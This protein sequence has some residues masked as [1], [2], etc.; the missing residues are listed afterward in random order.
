[1]NPIS[2]QDLYQIHF[3]PFISIFFNKPP[4]NPVYPDLRVET[5]SQPVSE[6]VDKLYEFILSEIKKLKE[7]EKYS[8]SLYTYV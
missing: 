8:N 7:N 3:S 4:E 6:S 1:M 2:P 5:S